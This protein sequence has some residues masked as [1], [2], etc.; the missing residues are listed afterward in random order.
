MASPAEILSDQTGLDALPSR[1]RQ[2]IEPYADRLD[3]DMIVRAY[4]FSERAHEGQKRAS[5]EAYLD[6]TVEV[7]KILA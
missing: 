1:L 4:R 3:V 5:G 6:H 7:A 2:S